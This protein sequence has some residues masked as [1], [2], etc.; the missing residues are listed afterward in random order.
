[1]LKTIGQDGPAKAVL[2]ES[3]S[4]FTRDR[5]FGIGANPRGHAQECVG[6]PGLHRS[7]RQSD[8]AG[9]DFSNNQARPAATTI[10]SEAQGQ[11]DATKPLR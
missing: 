5:I 10:Q 4:M 9:T 7:Y 3:Y 11:H 2:P 1:M 6:S 8:P